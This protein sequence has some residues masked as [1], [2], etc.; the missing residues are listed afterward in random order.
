V[1]RFNHEI[2]GVALAAMRR[3]AGKSGWSEGI[4]MN[5]SPRPIS[6]NW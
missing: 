3:N 5:G 6:G 4:W 2:R 1:G